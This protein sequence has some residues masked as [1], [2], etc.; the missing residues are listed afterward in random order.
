MRYLICIFIFLTFVTTVPVFSNETVTTNQKL[1]MAENNPVASVA[2][3]AYKMVNS[4]I[5]KAIIVFLF[6]ITGMGFFIGKIS[7]GIVISLLIGT[8]LTLTSGRLV[9]VFVGGAG[10]GGGD[11]DVCECKYGLNSSGE[12]NNAYNS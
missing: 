3:K 10:T 7:W 5:T 1:K 2:C 6:I 9:K 8:S 12:C 4:G 11:G